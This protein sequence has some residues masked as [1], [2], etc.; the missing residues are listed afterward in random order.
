MK[1]YLEIFSLV[2]IVTLSSAASAVPCELLTEHSNQHGKRLITCILTN[3]ENKANPTTFGQRQFLIT[4]EINAD[5]KRICIAE[6]NRL[7]GPFP[8]KEAK[9]ANFAVC[10]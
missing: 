7:E 10:H 6:F 4:G 2:S 8:K 3:N 1:R 9:Y 5:T